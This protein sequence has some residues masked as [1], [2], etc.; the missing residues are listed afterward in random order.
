M[1]TRILN[2]LVFYWVNYICPSHER[3]R[4][5]LIK[6][7]AR[8]GKGTRFNCTTNAFGS[9]PYLITVGEDCLF[10]A[11]TCFV[12]HDGGIKVL[13]SLHK[14]RQGD[15]YLRMDKIA[16]IKLGNN[17]YTGMH[18]MIMPGVT[19]GNN[20]IIGACSVVTHD[21]PSN[22]IVA[23]VPAR[24]ICSLDEYY[25]RSINKVEPTPTLTY[26]QKKEYY[27]KKF[28]IDTSKV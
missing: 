9:E 16:P 10:A 19:V 26:S 8:I 13:N 15:I 1:M 27:L 24:I 21:V 4:R 22:C 6:Q 20:V 25:A 11:N 23:G 14:Y 28:K 12:T 5:F 2:T 17:V 18:A 3:K 7:G